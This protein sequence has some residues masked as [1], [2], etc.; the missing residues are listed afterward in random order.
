MTKYFILSLSM[1]M[2]FFAACSKKATPSADSQSDMLR[3]GKWRI[4]S[5]KL[6]VKLPNG[7]DTMLDYPSWIPFCHRD[8]YF[9]FNSAGKGAVFNGGITCNPGEADSISFD[10]TLSNSG[11]YL[12][13]YN[14]FHLYYSV[15]ESILPF[16]VD[17]VSIDPEIV[18][19]TVWRLHFD[20]TSVVNT[21]IMNGVISNFSQ[22]SFTLDFKLIAQYPDSLLL[23]EGLPYSMPIIRPDTFKYKVTYSNF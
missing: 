6:T 22:S 7:K 1:A 14:S 11:N 2:L 13:L 3:K 12:S 5:G 9:V 16:S 18:L 21:D 23:H 17:T 10:W 20:T 8:D 15:T 19:D 4:T